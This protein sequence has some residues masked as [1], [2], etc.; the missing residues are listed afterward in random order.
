MY[1]KPG[2]IMKENSDE[3]QLSFIVTIIVAKLLTLHSHQLSLLIFYK[4]S[5]YP[6]CFE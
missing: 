3:T 1:F 6:K 2:E 4:H 5:P